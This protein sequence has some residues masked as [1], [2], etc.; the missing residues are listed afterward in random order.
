MKLIFT[1]T[2]FEILVSEGRSVL[3]P[4]Q[5]GTG[6]E[7]VKVSMKSPKNIRNL[8]KLLEK[9]F[10]Y[11]PRRLSMA[12]NF[13]LFCLIHSLYGGADIKENPLD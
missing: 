9:W 5:Q 2:V 12:F 6:S 10:T 3:S 8:L 4:T 13:F 7:R 1:S 11:E